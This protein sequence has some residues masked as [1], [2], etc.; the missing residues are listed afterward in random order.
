MTEFELLLS[1]SDDTFVING[2]AHAPDSDHV[3][4]ARRAARTSVGHAHAKG[5]SW[6]RTCYPDGGPR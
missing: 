4:A 5:L 6:C 3:A 1:N 2:T